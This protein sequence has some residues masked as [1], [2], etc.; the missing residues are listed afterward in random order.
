[1]RSWLCENRSVSICRLPHK[2]FYFFTM[3]LFYPSLAFT[4]M[5]YEFAF[6]ID[7][8]SVTRVHYISWDRSYILS[9]ITSILHYPWYPLFLFHSDKSIFFC[10]RL[11]HDHATRNS[12]RL[13]FSFSMAF[14]SRVFS[15]FFSHGLSTSRC[16]F[17]QFDRRYLRS[18]YTQ[19]GHS[20]GY[21]IE[22]A[23]SEA[24]VHV[25][26]DFVDRILARCTNLSTSRW[27]G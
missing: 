1:M 26:T 20:V 24:Y 27:K 6:T 12:L 25:L 19:H 21:S 18:L 23:G 16:S 2:I 9:R 14:H 3:T 15:S 7:N 5:D 10:R 8:Y 4:V 11:R 13:S 17:S 22:A